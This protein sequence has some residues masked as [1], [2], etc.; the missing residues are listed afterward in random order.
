MPRV[1]SRAVVLAVLALSA[2]PVAAQ[3]GDPL[4]LARGLRDNGLADLAVEYLDRV[5]AGTPSPALAALLPLERAQARLDLAGDEADDAKRDAL[6]AKAKAEFEQFLAT[7]SN[8]PRRA[9]AAVALARVVSAQA[10]SV[11][12]RSNKLADDAQRKAERA[13]PGPSSRTRPSGSA[14]PPS[15]TRRSSTTPT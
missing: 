3:P 14:M 8:H 11:L 9:E 5:A 4:D 6:I 7:Q 10:K 15:L 1:L 12:S 2:A 13:R